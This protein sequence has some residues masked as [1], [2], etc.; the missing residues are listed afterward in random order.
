MSGRVLFCITE[1]DAG[2]ANQERLGCKRRHSFLL[3][4]L[5]IER[6]MAR[7]AWMRTDVAELVIEDV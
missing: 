4:E 5:F 2:G 3:V 7:T 1:G 6:A